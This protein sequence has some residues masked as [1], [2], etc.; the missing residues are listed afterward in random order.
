MDARCPTLRGMLGR[1][2]LAARS[3]N[4]STNESCLEFVS[5]LWLRTAVAAWALWIGCA[6]FAVLA[7]ATS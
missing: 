4:D 6:A 1:M 3:E 7:A 2:I 5:R